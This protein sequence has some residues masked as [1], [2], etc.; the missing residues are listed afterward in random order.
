[1]SDNREAIE[2]KAYELWEADGRPD[3]RHDD[4]WTQAE[5]VMAG[6]QGGSDS[7]DQPVPNPAT[8][9]GPSTVD[10]EPYGTGSASGTEPDAR[11]SSPKTS[12]AKGRKPAPRPS[13]SQDTSLGP[14]DDLP[15]GRPDPERISP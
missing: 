13:P 4:H 2:R 7:L 8:P 10:A 12:P 9:P 6:S 5:A 15:V 3:G 11:S 14:S 1:M